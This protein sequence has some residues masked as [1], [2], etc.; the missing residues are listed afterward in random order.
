LNCGIFLANTGKM[1]VSCSAKV[2]TSR[3]TD[4]VGSTAIDSLP[5]VA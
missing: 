4:D 3:D 1:Y 5:T 2:N